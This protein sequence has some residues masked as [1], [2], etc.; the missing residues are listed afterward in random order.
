MGSACPFIV[1]LGHFSPTPVVVPPYW[2]PSRDYLHLGF[3]SCWPP[4]SLWPRTGRPYFCS[5]SGSAYLWSLL[6]WASGL[7]VCACL[8][9]PGLAVS[10]L[11]VSHTPQQVTWWGW[12]RLTAMPR[13]VLSNLKLDP[14]LYI[15]PLLIYAYLPSGSC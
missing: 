9:P 15:C 12:K 10:P 3:H 13:D 8:P 2:K 7:V 1:L 14:T 5:H 4:E 11:P 6:A